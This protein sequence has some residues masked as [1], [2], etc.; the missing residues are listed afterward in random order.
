M[1][2]NL[3]L[4]RD[5]YQII[6]G[7]PD[8]QFDLQWFYSFYPGD[9]PAANDCG[10]IACAGGWL[11][12]HPQFNALG[13]EAGREGP[14]LDGKYGYKALGEIFNIQEIAA[15]R[16][17]SPRYESREKFGTDKAVFLKRLKDFIVT[18]ANL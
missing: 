6:D 9:L 15:E 10:T 13:L 16:L 12:L 18:L 14:T 2:P 7:I 17:F 5:A 1:K 3:E 11:A 8:N 4:L